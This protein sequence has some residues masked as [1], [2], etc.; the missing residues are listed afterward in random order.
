MVLREP[1]LMLVSAPACRKR[2][3][4]ALEF[5]EHAGRKSLMHEVVGVPANDRIS[6]D[7]MCTGSPLQAA[8]FSVELERERSLY[9]RWRRPRR[10]PRLRR[11]SIR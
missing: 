11:A 3:I 10:R 8:D 4:H 6:P 2:R 5:I 7:R 9:L 1:L